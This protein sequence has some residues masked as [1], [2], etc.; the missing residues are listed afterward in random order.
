MIIYILQKH[1]LIVLIYLE[2]NSICLPLINKE[3]E[4]D[5]ENCQA[6]ETKSSMESES[7]E[8]FCNSF[9]QI[10]TELDSKI[11]LL[12]E[13]VS[14]LIDI[15]RERFAELIEYYKRNSI[16]SKAINEAIK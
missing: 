15:D 12:K 16:D 14:E 2:N 6:K 10:E 13:K 4:K 11:S 7:S 5:D 1:T 3:D 8:I 9:D